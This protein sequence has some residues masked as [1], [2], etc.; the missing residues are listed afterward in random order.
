[1]QVRHNTG[2]RFVY[3]LSAIRPEEVRIGWEEYRAEMKK[4]IFHKKG[5][6]TIPFSQVS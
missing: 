6:V 5:R 3:L 1:M 4:L 2:P